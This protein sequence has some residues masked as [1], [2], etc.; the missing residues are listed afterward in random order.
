MEEKLV[1]LIRWG[2]YA[3]L[4]VMVFS[5][6]GLLAG[7]FLPGDSLLVTAGLV[8]TTSDALNIWL[9]ILLLSAAAIAG[10]STGYAIGYHLGPRL[11]TRKDSWLFHK[12]HVERT[13]AFFDRYG[14]KTIVLARFVPIVRT[15][16]PT[17]AGVGNMRYRTF[18]TFNVIGG[19]AWV[20]SMTLAGYWLGRLVP[21]IES[22]LHWIIAMVI[23]ASFIPII[24]ELRRKP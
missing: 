23:I 14:A 13:Q 9:L 7:F 8:A 17:L 4:V 2:G 1:E 22:K 12:D 19:I 15:F 20:A 21:D 24:R 16:A 5:E 18:V 10:D 11:F 3:V 6:T